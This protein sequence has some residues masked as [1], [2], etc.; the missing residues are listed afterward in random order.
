[1]NKS[2][3]IVFLLLPKFLLSLEVTLL[4]GP[5]GSGKGTFGQYAKERGYGHIS[6][7]DLIRDQIKLKTNLG[8]AIEETVKKGQYIDPA[9]MFQLVRERALQYALRN[10]SF[11]IDGYGRTADDG[12]KLRELIQ[13][14]KAEARVL[15]LEAS[16]RTCK[17]RILG[18]LV[19]SSCNTIYNQQ[20][21]YQIE[22]ACPHCQA[23]HLEVRLNDTEHVIE[24]RLK[25][26]RLE[27]EPCYRSFLEDMPSISYN[28]ERD[29]ETIFVYYNSL[30]ENL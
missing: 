20:F 2:I 10:Q 21:G 27:I 14:L 25:Q 4:F 19:C 7:G 17:E 24:K 23:G 11:I 12:A 30:L 29:F 3:F 16:D 28:T 6:A 9:V 15:F 22:S 8:I 5:P 18:R 13:E 1:M 26:Y